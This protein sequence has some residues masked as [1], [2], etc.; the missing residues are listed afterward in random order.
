MKNL[1]L[2]PL[3]GIV[4]CGLLSFT[5]LKDFN[6]V[7]DGTYKA[8]LS[9]STTNNNTTGFIGK[10]DYEVEMNVKVTDNSIKSISDRRRNKNHDKLIDLPLRIDNEG[11]A[12]TE[13][14]F[15]EQNIR[16]K[17]DKG[18]FINYKLIIKKEELNK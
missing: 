4:M 7:K 8:Y 6:Q 2:L 11:N 3:L 15:Y 14:S 5:Y 1:K 12:V 17:N 13:T 16:N 10:S 9:S 18:S